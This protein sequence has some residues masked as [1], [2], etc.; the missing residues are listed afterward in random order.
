MHADLWHGKNRLVFFAVQL[1]NRDGHKDLS[2]F[3]TLLKDYRRQKTNFIS[4]IVNYLKE[5][6]GGKND[7]L[8]FIMDKPEGLPAKMYLNNYELLDTY[9]LRILEEPEF[10]EKYDKK[11]LK[12][13]EKFNMRAYTLLTQLTGRIMNTSTVSYNRGGPH[14]VIKAVKVLEE[15]YNDKNNVINILAH[16][17]VR[18][19][20]FRL[21]ASYI[22]KMID[23][24]MK[25]YLGIK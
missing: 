23:K 15:L 7:V 22:N 12:T 18:N 19:P 25:Q 9:G 20:N 6:I 14:T 2:Y 17:S 11:L 13:I 8:V 10:V 16:T 24:E 3:K 5:L 1:D 21:T 4:S